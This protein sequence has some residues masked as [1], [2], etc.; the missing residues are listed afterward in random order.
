LTRSVDLYKRSFSNLNSSAGSG[1]WPLSV[2][3]A[4]TP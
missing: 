1:H 3:L 4:G 2:F